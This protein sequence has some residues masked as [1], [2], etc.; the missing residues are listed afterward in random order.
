[1]NK[2]APTVALLTLLLLPL[3]LLGTAGSAYARPEETNFIQADGAVSG[4][5]KIQQNGNVYTF[6][7]NVTGSLTVERDNVVVDGA[8]YTLEGGNRGI[9]IANRQNVTVKNAVV[10]LEG[11]YVIDVGDARDC[12][13]INNTLIGTPKPLVLPGFEDM[14]SPALIGPIAVNFLH[15]QNMTVVNNTMVN[16]FYALS[17]EWS[18]G[19]TIIGNNLVDGI[20]GITIQN[21]TGCVFRDNHL[22]NCSFS[23]YTYPMYQYDNDL[24]SSNTVD[25]K[26]IV[27]WLNEKDKMVPSDA[28]YVALVNCTGIAV[29]DCNPT[30]IALVSTSNSTVANVTMTGR[31]G[32][33][34]KLLDCTGVT[35]VGCNLTDGAIAIGIE[36]SSNNTIRGNEIST[37]LTRGINLGNASNNLIVGNLLFNN[38]YALATSQDAVSTGNVVASNNFTNNGF[39]VTVQGNMQLVNNT[40]VGNEQAVLCYSGSNNITGNTFTG[41][42]RGVILQSTGNTLRGN[43]FVGNNDSLPINSANFDNNVDLTNT[44]NGKPMCYWVNQH[45]QTVPPDAGFLVLVNCSGITAQGLALTDQSNGVLLA[46]TSDSKITGNVIAGNTNGIYLYGAPNNAFLG[47]NVTGN[48]YAVYI[49]GGYVSFLGYPPMTYTPSSGNFFLQNNFVGNNQTLYDLAGAYQVNSPPSTNIWDNGTSGN[50]WSTYM[51]ID[52]DGDGVGDSGFVVYAKNTD[53]HPLMQAVTVET[54]PEFPA[55]AILPL[56]GAVAF[57]VLAFK[58]RALSKPNGGVQQ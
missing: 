13:L 21:T 22:S 19:N 44:L 3:M 15:S 9:V 52:A 38:S 11:G 8:G 58:K 48:G 7:G 33:G 4:T 1:M 49:S 23:T 10:L 53:N 46:F 6:T 26:P 18:Y 41:N 5:D 17:L 16:F 39:A 29:Q 20:L 12:A 45:N 57:G 55:W 42:G 32:D 51:G 24:D 35:I 47:N 54:I 36:N 37:Q 25:G 43:S 27:Y 28:A 56:F 50:Y 14:P 34:I 40:F 30:G 2:L 31:R